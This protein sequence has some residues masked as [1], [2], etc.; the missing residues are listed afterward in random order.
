MVLFLLGD[1]VAGVILAGVIL[2]NCAIVWPVIRYRHA[3]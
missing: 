3:R 1:T 2:I